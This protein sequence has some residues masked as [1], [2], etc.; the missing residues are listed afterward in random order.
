M[1]INTNTLHGLPLLKGLVSLHMA[2]GGAS[3]AGPPHLDRLAHGVRTQ[4]EVE[5]VIVLPHGHAAACLDPYG[6]LTHL[7]TCMPTERTYERCNSSCERSSA[8]SMPE[9]PD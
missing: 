3:A 2:Q 7:T 1:H 8:A 6:T 4:P 9:F 5:L